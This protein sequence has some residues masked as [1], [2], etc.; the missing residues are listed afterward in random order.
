[1]YPGPVVSSTV[2]EMMTD[3]VTKAETTPG[4]ESTR[5]VETATQMTNNSNVV[6]VQRIVIMITELIVVWTF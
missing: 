2:T 3:V 5:E 1:M 4:R 6:V